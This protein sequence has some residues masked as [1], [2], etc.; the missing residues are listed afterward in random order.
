MKTKKE[1]LLPNEAIVLGDFAE[2][3][4]FIIQDEIQSYHWSK[5]YCTLHPIVVYFLDDHGNLSHKSFCFIS[6]DNQHDTCFVHRVQKLLIDYMKINYPHITMLFYFSDG[7]AGQ[8]KNRKNLINLCHHHDN[9]G[10]DAEWIF[11]ATSHGK[12][13]CDGIGGF[14]KRHVAKRSLQHPLN[15]QILDHKAMINLCIEEIKDIEFIEISQE[16]IQVV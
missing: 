15:N 2:N 1:S 3:Y 12:S 4:Q 14:V 16:E 10:L 9:F 5:E 6:N 11:F 8:Y 13:P 7:C